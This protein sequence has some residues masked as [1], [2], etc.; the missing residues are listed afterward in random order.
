MHVYIQ[1][2]LWAPVYTSCQNKGFPSYPK[3]GAGC[4]DMPMSE[5]MYIS[6]A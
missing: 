3:K 5:L 4:T 6:V 1:V 2:G